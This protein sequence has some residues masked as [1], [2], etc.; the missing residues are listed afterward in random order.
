MKQCEL[1][2]GQIVFSKAGRDKGDCFVVVAVEGEFAHLV[3]GKTRPIER[4]KKK[5]RMHIQHTNF[6]DEQL[7]QAIVSGAHLKN[8]DFRTVIMVF[9]L[10]NA[11]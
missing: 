11:F 3:D 7:A 6:A 10:K 4:P 5:K 2:I 9:R 1:R 8:S